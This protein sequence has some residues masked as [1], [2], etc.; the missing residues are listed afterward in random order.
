MQGFI[1]LAVALLPLGWVALRVWQ[2]LE[3]FKTWCYWSL[4]KSRSA[5]QNNGMF[6]TNRSSTIET[7]GKAL[8]LWL[9]LNHHGGEW[10]CEYGV[11]WRCFGHDAVGH[12]KN[13]GLH[14]KITG[15]FGPSDQLCFKYYAILCRSNCVTITIGASDPAS[16]ACMGDVLD[17]ALLI[18]VKIQLWSEFEL[19]NNRM[20]WV[21]RPS[22]RP[23][24]L[25]TLSLRLFHYHHGGEWPCEYGK[26]WMFFK[27]L[28][29]GSSALIPDHNLK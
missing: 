6:W 2:A 13:P 8:S 25:I 9:C 20:F 17:S 4:S 18:L 5:P 15:C 28:G 22:V 16:M 1:A 21:N 26:H 27:R 3:M 12:C 7:L 10:P 11:H 19:R 14:P 29:L 23:K 24:Y